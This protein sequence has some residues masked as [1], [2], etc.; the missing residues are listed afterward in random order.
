MTRK[1]FETTA[2]IIK[3]ADLTWEQRVA[4]AGKFARMFGEAN[5]RFDSA[6]FFAAAKADADARPEYEHPKR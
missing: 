4:I 5:P 2:T 6:R 1:H 3:E